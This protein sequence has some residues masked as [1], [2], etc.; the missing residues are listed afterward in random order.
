VQSCHLEILREQA[1]KKTPGL[2]SQLKSA[3]PAIQQAMDKH[4]YRQCSVTKSIDD[5]YWYVNECALC[6]H[7]TEA[8]AIVFGV[9][10]K[11]LDQ[12]AKAQL[13]NG[14]K[15]SWQN[16]VG[17]LHRCKN[18][19]SC[20]LRKKVVIR[21]ARLIQPKRPKVVDNWLDEVDGYQAKFQ[22]LRSECGTE[23]YCDKAVLSALD[24]AQKRVT[25]FQK[26]MR[27]WAKKTA[28]KVHRRLK[29]KLTMTN[30]SRSYTYT[31]AGTSTAVTDWLTGKY[32]HTEHTP[33]QKM[34]STNYWA[35]ATITIKN[36]SRF[37]ISSLTT[38]IRCKS[39]SY[40]KFKVHTRNVN[41]KSKR[42]SKKRYFKTST[43]A[44]KIK[45]YSIHVPLL[46]VGAGRDN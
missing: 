44:C 9:R 10:T 25:S 40:K 14:R 39:P 8:K 36:P 23:N 18:V 30:D 45:Q 20:R 11:N 16:L 38:V 46:G 31:R 37:K 34:S 35:D 43:N 6:S 19:P 24:K 29:L 28:L 7:K 33:A 27:A 42:T 21:L 22:H 1:H 32:S 3:T 5:C 26:K 41:P 4:M 2:R 15:A 13:R 17:Y 12:Y